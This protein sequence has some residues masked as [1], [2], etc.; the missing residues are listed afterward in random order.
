MRLLRRFKAGTIGIGN[1][2][3]KRVSTG[4]RDWHYSKSAL[5]RPTNY[6]V[7]CSGEDRRYF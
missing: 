4:G 2:F 6:M 3:V 1:H 7:G 5:D